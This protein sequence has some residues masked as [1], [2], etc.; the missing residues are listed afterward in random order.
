MIFVAIGGWAISFIQFN[1]LFPLT[2][3]LAFALFATGM[4]FALRASFKVSYDT[5]K[6]RELLEE[7]RRQLQE[8]IEKKAQQVKEEANQQSI[9]NALVF[10]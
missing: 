4:V 7:A 1:Q 2:F 8:T 6:N 9:I 10:G 5:K 3:S